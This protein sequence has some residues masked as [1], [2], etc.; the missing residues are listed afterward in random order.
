MRVIFATFTL[1]EICQNPI[2][3]LWMDSDGWPL[4]C[5][6][7]KAQRRNANHRGFPDCTT[8]DDKKKTVG[9]RYE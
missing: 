3:R 1:D 5:S 9:F 6:V 4:F 2:M 7:L 8:N